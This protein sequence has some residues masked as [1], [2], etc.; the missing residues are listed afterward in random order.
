[1]NVLNMSNSYHFVNIKKIH[2]YQ[3]HNC[4]LFTYE[5]NV[6]NIKIS[7]QIEI[8]IYIYKILFIFFGCIMNTFFREFYL[9]VFF[10]DDSLLSLNKNTINF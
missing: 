3:T 2:L 4:I 8:Y 7:Y 5:K 10:S 9:L 6:I 1:M